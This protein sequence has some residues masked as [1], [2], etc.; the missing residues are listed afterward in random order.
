MINERTKA[1]PFW[2]YL[3]ICYFGLVFLHISFNKSSSIVPTDIGQLIGGAFGGAFTVYGFVC[4]IGNIRIG[5][6]V[7]G[8]IREV[9]DNINKAFKGDNPK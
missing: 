1:K 2:I 9:L 7:K 3:L 8:T 4:F 5:K 6:N